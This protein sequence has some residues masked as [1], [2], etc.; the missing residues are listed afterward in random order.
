M[1]ARC[2]SSIRNSYG[3]SKS[4]RRASGCCATYLLRAY[5]PGIAKSTNKLIYRPIG[6]RR[7]RRRPVLLAD[8]HRPVDDVVFLAVVGRLGRRRQAGGGVAQPL[9]AVPAI[10]RLPGDGRVRVELAYGR[11]G[12]EIK[13]GECHDQSLASKVIAPPVARIMLDLL[14]VIPVKF[15]KSA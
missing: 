1:I 12:R 6:V 10:G 5:R 11:R 3:S 7:P 13:R 2:Y 15:A 9:R 4:V 14:T 8:L